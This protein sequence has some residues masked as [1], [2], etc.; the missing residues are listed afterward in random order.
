M[1]W[2]LGKKNGQGQLSQAASA[3]CATGGELCPPW[4][5]DAW[6]ESTFRSSS[7]SCSATLS[8]PAVP[9]PLSTLQVKLSGSR[10]DSPQADS[11]SGLVPC[12]LQGLRTHS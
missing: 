9:H 10:G 5:V 1:G 11:P 4:A 3:S 7:V 6:A 8:S 12:V 2:A